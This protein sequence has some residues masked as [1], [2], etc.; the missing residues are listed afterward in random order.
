M[1][2]WLAIF[3]G[4]QFLG[5]ARTN[6]RVIQSHTLESQLNVPPRVAD[7]LDHACMD[8]H[9]D[10]TRWPWYSRVA[11]V[12][13][14]LVDHVNSGREAL[15]FS[16]WTQYPPSFASATLW[17]MAMAVKRDLMPLDSY[18]W[19]HRDAR[20]SS[21]ET[22]VFCDWS[23]TE[24]R[25]LRDMLLNKRQARTNRGLLKGGIASLPSERSK[26]AIQYTCPM[27]P[28]VVRDEPGKCPKCG[29]TLVQKH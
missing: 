3:A 12:R 26:A 4:I 21:A 17:T 9:S 5:P 16:D 6:P 2:A 15:N 22:K 14:W 28:E 29:M 27:H 18:K 8:C 23:Q 19:L 1:A 25:R 7:I 13:W 20:L 11:P 10:A 24:S